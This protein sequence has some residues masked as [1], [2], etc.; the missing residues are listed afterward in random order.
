MKKFTKIFWSITVS[1]VVL[2]AFTVP[3]E[4]TKTIVFFG[5]SITNRGLRPG[6]YI[7]LIQKKLEQDG[8]ADQYTLIGAGHEGN[9]VPDLQA[10]VE[11]DV[12][13]KKPTLVFIYIG[14]NDVWKSINNPPTHT[15]IDQYE[16]GLKEI[17]NKIKAAGAKVVLCTPTVIGEKTNGGNP[18]DKM[19]N[20]YAS[21]SKKVARQ[22]K[23]KLCDLRKS[24]QKYLSKNNQKNDQKGILT[25]DR[26]HLNKQGNELVAQKMI[27][28]LD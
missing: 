4:E 19:L 3:G 2:T 28:F 8:V 7:D 27:K 18:Q 9:T 25:L 26:V 23:S 20:E 24:F 10:R 17:I 5:D 11:R 21:V 12:I 14:I 22:T 6:G 13:A 1:I 15:P 16:A